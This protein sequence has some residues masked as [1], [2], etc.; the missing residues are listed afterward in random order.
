[1][2]KTIVVAELRT[3]LKVNV[4]YYTSIEDIDKDAGKAGFALNLCNTYMQQKSALPEANDFV[5]ECLAALVPPFPNDTKKDKTVDV[6]DTKGNVIG[7]K[8]INTETEGERTNRFIAAVDEGTVTYDSIPKGSALA[9]LQAQL[10]KHGVF[11]LDAKTPVRASKPKEPSAFAKAS[12]DKIFL[13]ETQKKGFIAHWLAK[14][15][16]EGYPVAVKD[17]EGK[18][19]DEAGVKTNMAWALDKRD[20]ARRALEV[21][22]EFSVPLK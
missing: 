11:N 18:P 17:L 1:M 13:G 5:V 19:L 7:K 10:D 4:G 16:K 2:S 9:W 21:E 8:T 20:A 22:K 15:D 12:V 6:K 3:G 14:L